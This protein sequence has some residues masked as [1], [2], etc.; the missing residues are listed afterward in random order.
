MRKVA[1][2][3]RLIIDKL[4]TVF[5]TQYTYWQFL[6]TGTKLPK[7]LKVKGKMDLIATGRIVL[8]D[9]ITILN[10]SHYNHAGINHPTQLIANKDSLLKIGDNVGIS[11]A[12]IYC[13]TSI[14]IG[15]YVNIGANA[16]IY[17]TDFHPLDYLA[18]RKYKPPECAPVILEDD[19]WLGKNVIVLKGTRIGARTVIAAGSIVTSNIPPDSLAAGIPAK[20]IKTLKNDFHHG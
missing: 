17:D 7:G 11:G 20:V 6:L 2:Y 1:L 4:F 14:T 15:N 3:P 12:S 10:N 16:A 18:R 9:N 13:S 8:G 5:W 19:V